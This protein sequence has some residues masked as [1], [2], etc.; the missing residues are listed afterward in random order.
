MISTCS[1]HAGICCYHAGIC[2]YH[3]GICSYYAGT[4]SYYSG[5]FSYYSGTCNYHQGNCIYQQLPPRFLQLVPIRHLQFSSQVLVVSIWLRS[6][7]PQ[8]SGRTAWDW[9]NTNKFIWIVLT[10]SLDLP[11]LLL[12]DCRLTY[13]CLSTPVHSHQCI[14]TFKRNACELI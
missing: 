10:G 1:Y 9:T 14:N 6:Y 7:L 13:H 8:F 11:W 4:C 2:S 5:T 3:A 12:V